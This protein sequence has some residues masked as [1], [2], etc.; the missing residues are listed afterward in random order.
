MYPLLYAGKEVTKP[1]K[2]Q[3]RIYDFAMACIPDLQTLP[4][5][6]ANTAAMVLNQPN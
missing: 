3:R 6:V 5:S 2:L 1:T 4:I